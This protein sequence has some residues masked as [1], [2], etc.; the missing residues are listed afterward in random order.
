MAYFIT[1]K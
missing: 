1:L